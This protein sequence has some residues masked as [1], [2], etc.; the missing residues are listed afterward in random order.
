MEKLT[1]KRKN[2]HGFT[3]Q[4]RTEELTSFDEVRRA[5]ASIE[6]LCAKAFIFLKEAIT[7]IGTTVCKKIISK[8]QDNLFLLDGLVGDYTQ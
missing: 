4:L 2:L 7:D 1:S 3:W 6:L 5:A 8:V